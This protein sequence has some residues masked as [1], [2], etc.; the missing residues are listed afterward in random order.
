MR[1][2]VLQQGLQDEGRDGLVQ[3]PRVGRNVDLGR[4]AVAEADLDNAEIRFSIAE[5][6]FQADAR[7]MMRKGEVE[8]I[9][10]V[11]EQSSRRFRAGT[12]ERYDDG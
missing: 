11:D 1:D 4:Q 2:G 12:D 3:K 9:G 8:H 10:Q 6:F 7:F 5:F